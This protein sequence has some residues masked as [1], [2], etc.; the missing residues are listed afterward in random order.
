M[1]S[2]SAAEGSEGVGHHL[3]TKL[4]TRTA[5]QSNAK[6]NEV[7]TTTPTTTIDRRVQDLVARRPGHLLHLAPHLAEVLTRRRA[8][9]LRV[10]RLPTAA[11]AAAACRR[12]AA[13]SVA[14][15]VGSCRLGSR[16]PPGELEVAIIVSR[17]GGT[18]T[19]NR[20]FWRPVLYQLSYCPSG[21]GGRRRG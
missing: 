3:N 5:S 18:R 15:S 4:T 8:L 10:R 13:P 14:W 21:R 7:I 17:A 9:D 2:P 20:R 12:P 19:P 11:R 16:S 6:I 1:S